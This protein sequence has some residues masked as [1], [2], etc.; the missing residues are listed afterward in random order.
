[1]GIYFSEA[2]NSYLVEMPEPL[3]LE[4][5]LHFSL[6]VPT[7]APFLLGLPDNLDA[8][9]QRLRNISQT[10]PDEGAFTI[11]THP[12]ELVSTKFWDAVN[13]G[14]GSTRVP[15]E[16]AP[17]R[18]LSDRARAIHALDQYFL[19]ASEMPGIVWIDVVEF[20]ARIAPR[21]S[22]EVERTAFLQAM[23]SRGLGPIRLNKGGLSAAECVYALA[24]F[25][26]HGKADWVT[27]PT[28]KAPI[29]WAP[30]ESLGVPSPSQSEAET[31]AVQALAI[32]ESEGALP[33]AVSGMAIE[34]W[35]GVWAARVVG[36]GLR[37][38][39]SFLSYVKEPSQLHWDW[40]IFPPEFQPYRLWQETRR[41]AWALAPIIWRG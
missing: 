36:E 30:S 28:L 9:I 14:H 18:S 19:A 6:P 22:V 3:W 29:S 35:A 39:L 12:T 11:M 32:M 16:P 26:V 4:D 13:F 25:V 38:A 17:L 23:G 41:L 37:P 5:V 8:A 40:P 2:W 34:R 1:M 33:A 15:L 24:Y 7:P 31:A 20:S 21:T 10:V 27:V